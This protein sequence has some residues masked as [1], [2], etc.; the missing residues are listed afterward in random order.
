MLLKGTLMIL[1]GIS[2]IVTIIIWFNKS[3][4]K[5]DINNTVASNKTKNQSSN[6][7]EVSK[8][9]VDDGIEM[10]N[11]Y[12]PIE[13]NFS[14]EKVDSTVLLDGFGKDS[15]IEETVLLEVDDTN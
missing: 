13:F 9:P 5:S 3:I 6:I 2:G 4:R 8:A 12:K 15:G 11:N 10:D 14:M 7:S 1:V